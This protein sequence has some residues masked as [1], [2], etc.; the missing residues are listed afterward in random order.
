MLMQDLEKWNIVL[1]EKNKKPRTYT[2][3]E[4]LAQMITS[5]FQQREA[6]LLQR[7]KDSLQQA[8]QEAQAAKAPPETLKR[9]KSMLDLAIFMNQFIQTISSFSSLSLQTLIQKFSIKT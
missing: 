9:I 2:A 8:Y 1:V 4:R 5:V 7:T 3:N 6:G